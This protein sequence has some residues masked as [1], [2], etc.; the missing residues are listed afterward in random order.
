MTTAEKGSVRIIQAN[1][2]LGTIIQGRIL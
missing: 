1:V 2:K